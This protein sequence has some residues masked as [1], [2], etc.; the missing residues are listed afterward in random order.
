ME[1]SVNSTVATK[2]VSRDRHARSLSSLLRPETARSDPQNCIGTSELGFVTQA[3]DVLTDDIK[4]R[5]MLG[6]SCA[7]ML[8]LSLCQDGSGA[9]FG[10][11]NDSRT[12]ADRMHDLA[13]AIPTGPQVRPWGAPLETYKRAH[14]GSHRPTRRVPTRTRRGELVPAF[15]PQLEDDTSL[16]IRGRGPI[17]GPELERRRRRKQNTARRNRTSA[18]ETEHRSQ[19]QKRRSQKQKHRSQKQ[20]R[21]WRHRKWQIKLS[22][23]KTNGRHSKKRRAAQANDAAR[24]N[25]AVASKWKTRQQKAKHGKQTWRP[26]ITAA[27]ENEAVVSKWKTRQ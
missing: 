15:P 24:E 5:Q 2:T 7:P 8:C 4:A 19:K 12:R 23:A 18:C 1:G 26:R 21:E 17:V 14:Q 6:A 3:G 10:R 22:T 16:R 27:K 9:L 13:K 25:E 20:K 11:S